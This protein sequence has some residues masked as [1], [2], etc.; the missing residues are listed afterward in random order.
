MALSKAKDGSKNYSLQT[1]AGGS[2]IA[3]YCRDGLTHGLDSNRLKVC[4]ICAICA[5][6]FNAIAK[7]YKIWAI[8]DIISLSGLLSNQCLS[9]KC[10]LNEV[11]R[12]KLLAIM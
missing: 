8:N 7:F 2:C 10:A 9:P 4:A 6:V 5:I 1:P 3:R 12:P 11:F